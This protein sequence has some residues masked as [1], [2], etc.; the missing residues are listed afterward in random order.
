MFIGGASGVFI[1]LFLFA[2]QYARRSKKYA[3][4]KAPPEIRLPMS[5]WGGLLLTVSM[6]W[7]GWTS[8][9]SISYWSPVFATVGIGMS[10]IFLF[11]ECLHF[12]RLKILTFLSCL[13]STISSIHMSRLQQVRSHQVPSWEA[14]SVRAFLWVPRVHLTISNG[15]TRFQ[16]FGNQMY[17]KLDPRIASTVLAACTL[18]LVPVPFVLEKYGPRLRRNSRY[19]EKLWRI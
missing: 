11:V 16:L 13:C 12:S 18:L 7:F 17:E 9:P 3:A 6:L 2:P 10:M 5:K 8:Y 19:A 14:H 1:Y 4:N 15:L